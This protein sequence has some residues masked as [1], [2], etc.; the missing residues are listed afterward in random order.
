MAVFNLLAH[1]K[2][3][4]KIDILTEENPSMV[5]DRIIADIF[6]GTGILGFEALSRG[7]KKVVFIDENGESLQTAKTNA[8]NLGVI[9]QCIFIQSDATNLIR[10]TIEVDMVLMD[11]PYNQNLV[12]PTLESI[13]KSGWVKKG[14]LVVAEYGK[15]DIVKTPESFELL[16]EREYNNTRLSF[17]KRI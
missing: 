2:F 3:L 16:D 15:K 12:T 1:G 14:G 4:H 13:A 9:D 5:Q 17:F 11:P 7:A 10:C 6:C 8:L